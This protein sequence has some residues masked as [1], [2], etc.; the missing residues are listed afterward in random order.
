MV[1]QRIPGRVLA[2]L[3]LSG[4]AG[5]TAHQRDAHQHSDEPAALQRG[6]QIGDQTEPTQAQQFGKEGS[7]HDVTD[8]EREEGEEFR[9]QCS[10]RDESPGQPGTNAADLVSGG[11][12]HQ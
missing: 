1:H 4:A 9:G 2:G 6:P 3:G 12:N 8:A 5:Q 10:K 11:V 7:T